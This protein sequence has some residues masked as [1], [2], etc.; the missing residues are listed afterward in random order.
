MKKYLELFQ[1]HLEVKNMFKIH[2]STIIL[3]KVL[4]TKWKKQI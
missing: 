1:K 2:L 3:E 4:I